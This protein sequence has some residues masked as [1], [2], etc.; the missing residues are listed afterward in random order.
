M[1]NIVPSVVRGSR[2]L[3]INLCCMDGVYGFTQPFYEQLI[4]VN[5]SLPMLAPTGTLSLR[6]P[7]KTM[8]CVPRLDEAETMRIVSKRRQS[9]KPRFSQ[10]E[11]HS[12]RR[13][14]SGR[15]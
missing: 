11:T 13:E 9:N 3:T 14:G 10:T 15:K 1:Q 12:Q 5:Q 7:I 6:I 8:G 2:I 4:T